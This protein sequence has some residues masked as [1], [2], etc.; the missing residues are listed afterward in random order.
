M[1]LI[2]KESSAVASPLWFAREAQ[3]SVFFDLLAGGK[4][5]GFWLLHGCHAVKL[6]QV[7]AEDRNET[8]IVPLTMKI[9]DCNWEPSAQQ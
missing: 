4:L 8:A 5:H 7:P 3:K 1:A 6:G 9:R 2:P